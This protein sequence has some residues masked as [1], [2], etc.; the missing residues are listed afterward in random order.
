MKALAMI[1]ARSGSKGL[2]DKNI[3][4]LA[5]KPMI[6]HSIIPAL[7]CNLIDSVYLNSDSE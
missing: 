3:L 6:A 2:K 4:D 1:P 7:N 5:G